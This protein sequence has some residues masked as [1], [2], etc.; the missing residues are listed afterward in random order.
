MKLGKQLVEELVDLWFDC[1]MRCEKIE[2][3]IK[4]LKETN[5]KP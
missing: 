2:Q 4:Q 3:L 5:I 1:K